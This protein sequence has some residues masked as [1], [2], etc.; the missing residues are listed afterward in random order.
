[1]ANILQIKWAKWT[2]TADLKALIIAADP[3]VIMCRGS[4]LDAGETRMKKS[5]KGLILIS[6]ISALS[7]ALLMSRS[8]DRLIISN[9]TYFNATFTINDSDC[10]ADILGTSGV[11][12][13]KKWDSLS[14]GIMQSLCNLDQTHCVIDFYMTKTNKCDGKVVATV[15][16]DTH[17]GIISVVNYQVSGVV[18]SQSANMSLSINGGSEQEINLPIKILK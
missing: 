16:L 12:K 9:N 17:Q 11:I 7:P 5:I 10:S 13:S 2:I 1:M 8:V 15:V 18:V 4:G 14:N 6:L 3:N